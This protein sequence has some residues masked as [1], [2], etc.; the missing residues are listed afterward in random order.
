M[1]IILSL[2][3]SILWGLTYVVDEQIYK[4]ISVFSSLSIASFF[5]FLVTLVLSF[6]LGDVRADVGIL[7]SSK[8]TL[9]LVG[10]GTITFITAEL[11]IGLSIH[12]RNAALAGLIE[13][14]YPIFIVLFTAIF[15]GDM[16]IN[17]MTLLGGLLI[18]F[19]VFL[20][21]YSN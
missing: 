13:V 4:Q 17:L 21:S 7:E 19:G 11:L 15:V 16:E 18:L 8:K 12:S 14:S 1:W 10:F 20:V 9:L 5:T 6:I 3:A 2:A